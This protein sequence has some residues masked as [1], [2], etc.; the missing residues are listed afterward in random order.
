M[1]KADTITLLSERD[2]PRGVHEDP[3]LIERE[4][5]CTVRSV[6]MQE[7]YSA[8]T[9]GVQTEIKFI[10]SQDFEYQ[11]ERRL[12]YHGDPYDIV[13]TYVTESDTIELTARRAV[14]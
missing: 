7:F 1:Q 2:N 4:V 11:G 13:R 6:G 14:D 3:E 10:L 8:L 5:Y 9:A 12:L